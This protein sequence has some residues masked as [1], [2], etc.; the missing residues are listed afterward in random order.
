MVTI[1]TENSREVP[2][3]GINPSQVQT[4]KKDTVV[5]KSDVNKV[6]NNDAKEKKKAYEEAKRNNS[7]RN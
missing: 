1:E 7:S 3:I 5:N 6:H 2:A 4:F